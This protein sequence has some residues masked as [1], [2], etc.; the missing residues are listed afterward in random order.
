MAVPTFVPLA[1]L[2]TT[3]NASLITIDSINTSDYRD[4][5]LYFNPIGATTSF[6]RIEIKL[7]DNNDTSATHKQ[8]VYY[9]NDFNTNTETSFNY[10]VAP[11]TEGSVPQNEAYTLNW[12]ILNA[13]GNEYTYVV[14]TQ[15][16]RYFR[17]NEYGGEYVGG[18]HQLAAQ[19]V[20][21][22]ISTPSASDLFGIGT[23]L[24]L[25]GLQGDI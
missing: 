25:Y 5:I 13:G 22:E 2:E 20:K 19:I 3:A 24:Q 15:G 18:V 10:F 9:S 21:I 1:E 17:E 23:K 8:Q 11:A 14:G 7:L 6:K 4:L 16:S 12:R